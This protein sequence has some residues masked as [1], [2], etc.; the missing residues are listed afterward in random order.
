LDDKRE[1]RAEGGRGRNNDS[2]NIWKHQRQLFCT[3]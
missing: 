1:G 2:V 3:E